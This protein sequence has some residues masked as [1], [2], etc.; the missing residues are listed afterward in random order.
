M[1]V[2]V[3]EYDEKAKEYKEGAAE[4]E[5]EIKE[6][7][8]RLAGEVGEEHKELKKVRCSEERTQRAGNALIPRITMRSEATKSRERVFYELGAKQ[9][10]N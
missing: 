6:H 9:L 1:K 4:K 10:V 2:K 8:E 7:K 3:T 5:E